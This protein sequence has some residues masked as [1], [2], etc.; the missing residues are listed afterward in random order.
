[1]KRALKQPIALSVIALTGMV[2][3]PFQR[4]PNPPVTAPAKPAPPSSSTIASSSGSPPPSTASRGPQRFLLG[5][6][7]QRT[8]LDVL[9]V[10]HRSHLHPAQATISDPRQSRHRETPPSTASR[11]R[12][13]LPR[14]APVRVPPPAASTRRRAR[15][16]PAWMKAQR[17]RKSSEPVRSIASFPAVRV[18]LPRFHGQLVS[19][20]DGV[21]CSFFSSPSLGGE[22]Q[23]ATP[24]CRFAS[25]RMAEFL[26]FVGDSQPSAECSRR[27]L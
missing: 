3:D 7:I 18:D 27:V 9:G 23:R 6:R 22:R 14:P 24:I 16:A 20:V 26:E 17:A 2:G 10:A 13:P 8:G 4:P 11:P 12:P 21:C 25:G 15:S 19:V 1:M 5:D